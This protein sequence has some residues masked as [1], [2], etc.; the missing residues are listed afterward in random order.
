MVLFGGPD[1]AS[2]NPGFGNIYRIIF[3]FLLIHHGALF[4]GHLFTG[5]VVLGRT[6]FGRFL[7]ALFFVPTFLRWNTFTLFLGGSIARRTV[8]RRFGFMTFCRVLSFAFLLAPTLVIVHNFTVF[9]GNLFT[10]VKVQGSTFLSGNSFTFLFIFFYMVRLLFPLADLTLFLLDIPILLDG[11]LPTILLGDLLTGQAGHL[12]ALFFIRVPAFLLGNL[13]AFLDI[14]TRLVGNSFTTFFISS[15]T[16]ILG[17]LFT[18][19]SVGRFTE[20][21][22]NTFT[23]LGVGCCTLLLGNVCT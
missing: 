16:K 15:C 17:I 12:D 3:A 6:L 13:D 20:L 21:L 19:L 23:G 11:H 5:I 8:V 10:I 1:T 18:F 14:L 4:A 7:C 9:I 22:G 2:Q